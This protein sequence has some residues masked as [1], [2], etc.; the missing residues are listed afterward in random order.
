MILT[1]C[2]LTSKQSNTT[3]TTHHPNPPQSSC[4]Q[5]AGDQGKVQRMPTTRGRRD[6]AAALSAVPFLFLASP[7]RG[8]RMETHHSLT[9]LPIP[10]QHRVSQSVLTRSPTRFVTLTPLEGRSR[11]VHLRARGHASPQGRDQVGADLGLRLQPVRQD[12]PLRARER[13]PPR[14]PERAAVVA[15]PDQ[16]GDQHRK[17][18]NTTRNETMHRNNPEREETCSSASLDR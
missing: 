12:L 8:A 14:R 13:H 10:R 16:Q 2:S 6:R 9:L 3:T 18:T 17:N 15:P 11:S 1:F 5:H 7:R 4:T